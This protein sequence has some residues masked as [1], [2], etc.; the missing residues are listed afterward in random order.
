MQRTKGRRAEQIVVNML[1]SH[2]FDARRNLSQTAEGGFDII[3][4]EPLAIE[5]KDHKKLTPAQWWKQT[6]ANA[7]GELIPVLIYHIPYTSTW[8]VQVPL[9]LIN[10]TLSSERVAT[11]EFDDFVCIAREQVAA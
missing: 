5:V 2:G 7:T 6:T 8:R 11:L 9:S 10:P 3:G 1:K 4:L